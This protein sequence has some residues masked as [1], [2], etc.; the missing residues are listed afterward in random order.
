MTVSKLTRPSSS[1]LFIFLPFIE[2]LVC[3]CKR[4]DFGFDAIGNNDEAV[5]PKELR[6]S[7]FVIADIFLIGIA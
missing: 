3:G 7:V 1:S 5:V 6:D 4:A 2:M